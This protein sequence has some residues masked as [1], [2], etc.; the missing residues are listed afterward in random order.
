M[1]P[2][3]SVRRVLTDFLDNGIWTPTNPCY[4]H[5]EE[6]IKGESDAQAIDKHTKSLEAL[7]ATT[8]A[9]IQKLTAILKGLSPLLAEI[10]TTPTR[11]P[12]RPH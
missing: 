9:E 10:K 7:K 1:E 4:S 6:R 8:E 5:I 12:S 2:E 11:Q 3:R